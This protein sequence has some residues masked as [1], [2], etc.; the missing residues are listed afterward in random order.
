MHLTIQHKDEIDNWLLKLDLK[1]ANLWEV[2]LSQSQKYT[3][4]ADI[5]HSSYYRKASNI[6][7]VI[8]LQLLSVPSKQEMT[9]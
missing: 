1:H 6:D 5:S 7:T 8:K 2:T 4:M 9:Q 3:L